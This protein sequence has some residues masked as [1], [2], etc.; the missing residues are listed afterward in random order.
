MEALFVVSH[1]TVTIAN[2]LHSRRSEH[3]W[4]AD[5]PEQTLDPGAFGV[6]DRTLRVVRRSAVDFDHSVSL[7]AIH[8]QSRFLTLSQEILVAKRTDAR[9]IHRC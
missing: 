5:V 6:G 8:L 1:Q 4:T 2:L 7:R 3:Q 9:K